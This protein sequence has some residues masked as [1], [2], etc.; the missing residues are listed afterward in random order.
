M[1]STLSAAEKPACLDDTFENTQQADIKIAHL[2]QRIGATDTHCL[3]LTK[4]KI[5]K[6]GFYEL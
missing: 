5:M 3:V 6:I 2:R 4:P 1:P